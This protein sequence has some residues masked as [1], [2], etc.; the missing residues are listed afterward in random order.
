[1]EMEQIH[2]PLFII[3][4]PDLD[5]TIDPQR[6][7]ISKSR[8][9]TTTML[10]TEILIGLWVMKYQYYQYQYDFIAQATADRPCTIRKLE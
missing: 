10:G 7:P 6:P 1:M 4:C 3:G 9:P 5:Q 2:Q 8:S